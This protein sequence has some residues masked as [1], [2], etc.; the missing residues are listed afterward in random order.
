MEGVSS[1]LARPIGSVGVVGTLVMFALVLLVV[2]GN[3]RPVYSPPEHTNTNT[4]THTHS[5]THTLTRAR[6]G[7]GLMGSGIA[8]ACINAQIPVTLLD[9]KEEYV[10]KGMKAIERNYAN[11][12]K[13]GKM[14]Y[15]L[16]ATLVCRDVKDS[17]VY[18]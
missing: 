2:R 3:S 13:R 4:H 9:I 7:A 8:T 6:K 14:T 10:A 11:Q 16:P 5:H 12:I 15:A 1:R 17:P 18:H